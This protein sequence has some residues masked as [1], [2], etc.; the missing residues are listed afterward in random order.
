MSSSSLC[1][2]CF[3][4]TNAKVYPDLTKVQPGQHHLYAT[5]MFVETNPCYG[6]CFAKCDCGQHCILSNMQ[7][8]TPHNFVFAVLVEPMLCKVAL[9]HFFS[10]ET[11]KLQLIFLR[12]ANINE[13]DSCATHFEIVLLSDLLFLLGN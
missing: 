13:T 3:S 8:F 9:T 4:L 5:R 10:C 1:N 7:L 2:F 6:V 12:Q 11:V